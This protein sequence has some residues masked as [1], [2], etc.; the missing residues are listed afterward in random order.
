MN[1]SLSIPCENAQ[2]QKTH[3]AFTALIVCVGGGAS[4]WGGFWS[5]E[6]MQLELEC[7]DVIACL[8]KLTMWS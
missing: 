2:S 7:D 4:N 3:L 1:M 6:Y 8:L 5:W